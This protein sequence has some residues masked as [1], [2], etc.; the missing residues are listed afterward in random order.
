MLNGIPIVSKNWVIIPKAHSAKNFGNINTI[1][2]IYMKM[3]NL[4]RENIN[5]KKERLDGIRLNTVMIYLHLKNSQ[6][7]KI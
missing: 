5:G 3:G 7:M 1:S 4:Q 6:K 2:S